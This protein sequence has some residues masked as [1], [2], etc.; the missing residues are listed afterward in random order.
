HARDA[1]D[2]ARPAAVVLY[3]GSAAILGG[4]AR[5]AVVGELRGRSSYGPHRGEP[6]DVAGMAVLRGDRGRFRGRERRRTGL[7][8]VSRVRHGGRAY[9][10]PR[11]RARRAIRGRA[12][13]E[14]I[15]EVPRGDRAGGARRWERAGGGGSGAVRG[16]GVPRQRG[17]GALG[18]GRVAGGGEATF[19]PGWW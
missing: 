6:H 14:R 5:G 7:G 8:A 16:R 1:H 19:G 2:P 9:R 12:S 13:G 3:G 15:R 18:G 17:G 4:A 11:A 10:E